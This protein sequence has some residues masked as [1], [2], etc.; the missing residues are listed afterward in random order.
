MICAVLS[1]LAPA[2]GQAVRPQDPA[3]VQ[4]DLDRFMARV[5]ERRDQTWRTLH[6]YVL[7]ETE[8]LDVTGPKNV[9]LHG[10]ERQFTWYV[11]DGYLIRSPLR[12][13]APPS[14][15]R[16]GAGIEEE[17]LHDEKARAER[18]RRN[19]AAKAGKP[20]TA[21]EAAPGEAGVAREG[22]PSLQPGSGENERR[23]RSRRSSARAAS[24]A[25]S[26]R[27]T[28]SASGSNRG[29]YYL[30]GHEQLDGREVVRVEYYPTALFG[31]T[32]PQDREGRPDRGRG[33][34]HPQPEQGRAGHAV[35]RSLQQQIVR[36]TFDNVDFGFLPGRWLVRVD[37]ITGSLTMANVFEGVCCR[38]RSPCGVVHAGERNLRLR[39]R[40]RVF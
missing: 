16:S 19:A 5:L 12:S 18:R 8:R 33:G 30:A 11:R 26:R 31:P 15:K 21:T 32:G 3:K 17:W 10:M 22:P 40:P 6:D 25:S 7:D 23:R 2:D 29:N 35:D 24:P 34:P 9:R 28:S 27:P 4:T 14:P 1:V 13:T 39:V 36:Y 38:S 37:K 20:V